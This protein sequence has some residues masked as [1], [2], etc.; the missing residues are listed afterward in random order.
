MQ[1]EMATVP[2]NV[3]LPKEIAKRVDAVVERMGQEPDAAA[4]RPTRTKVILL[5]LLAGLP[6]LEK[7][8]RR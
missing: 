3:R 7:R 4:E 5:A 2:V 6:V 1:P 8:R